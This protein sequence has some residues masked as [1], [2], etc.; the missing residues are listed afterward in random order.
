MSP[1]WLFLI[2]LSVEGSKCFQQKPFRG[3]ASIAA[4]T[5]ANV[6][7]PPISQLAVATSVA[8]EESSKSNTASSST[9]TTKLFV[10]DPSEVN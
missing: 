9:T 2:F 4:S 5:R 1:F 7:P 6:I 10:E 8:E 3:G